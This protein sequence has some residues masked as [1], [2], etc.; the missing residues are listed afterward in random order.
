MTTRDEVNA[1][2]DEYARAMAA[3]DVAR[4]TSLYAPEARLLFSDTPVVEGLAAV[5]SFHTKELDSGS[6]A[7]T[8]DSIDVIDAGELVVDIGYYEGSAERGKYVVVFRR[9]ADGALKIV[10]EADITDGFGS[11]TDGAR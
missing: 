1:I 8:F 2:N 6:V 5:E 9:D 4:M 3:Q 11:A 10:I 7:I